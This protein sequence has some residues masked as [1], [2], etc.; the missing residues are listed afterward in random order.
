MKLDFWKQFVNRATQLCLQERLLTD[1]AIFGQQ[2]SNRELVRSDQ[3]AL[4]SRPARATQ[5]FSR[6]AGRQRLFENCAMHVEIFLPRAEVE[7]LSVVQH[8]A[9]DLAALR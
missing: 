2:P 5:A 9:A 3:H 7:P 8:H 4:I 6:N 1:A